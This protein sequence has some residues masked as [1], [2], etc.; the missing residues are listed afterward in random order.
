MARKRRK[1]TVGEAITKSNKV[2]LNSHI[3]QLNNIEVGQTCKGGEPKNRVSRDALTTPIGKKLG[4][5]RKWNTGRKQSTS[6]HTT[7]IQQEG[8]VKGAIR[9]RKTETSRDSE[10]VLRKKSEKGCL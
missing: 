6:Y 2:Q 8:T 3:R 9:P 5:G 1:K 10:Q 4:G 7:R